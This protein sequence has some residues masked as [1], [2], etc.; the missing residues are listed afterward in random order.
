[1]NTEFDFL[2][3]NMREGAKYSSSSS[4][5]EG[6]GGDAMFHTARGGRSRSVSAGAASRRSYGA[7]GNNN[8]RRVRINENDND[9]HSS[10]S[11]SRGILGSRRDRTATG[12][13]GGGSNS[14]T[15]P[16][17]TS[18]PY[19]QQSTQQ[20]RP[21][22]NYGFMSSTRRF[23]STSGKGGKDTQRT[24]SNSPSRSSR[25]S[26]EDAQAI[27]A[28]Q[29]T[30]ATLST[31]LDALKRTV[32]STLKGDDHSPYSNMI[33]N[34]LSSSS[35]HTATAVASAS[36]SAAGGGG[37]GGGVPTNHFA[38]SMSTQNAVAADLDRLDWRLAVGKRH[39]L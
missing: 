9:E 16:Q 23:N 11:L 18:S 8:S 15:S 12:G 36:T 22:E 38:A 25:L 3:R 30:V 10:D 21:A 4:G 31:E 33:Y 32:S 14:R 39:L 35:S 34:K 6:E 1:M 28:L 20:Q 27:A 5:G 2:I 13:G 29:R 37:G 19:Q 26:E 24:R 7:S 17:R